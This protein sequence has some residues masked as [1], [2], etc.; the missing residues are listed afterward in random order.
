[1]GSSCS[2]VTRSPSIA[3]NSICVRCVAVD[4][5]WITLSTSGA[6]FALLQPFSGPMRSRSPESRSTTSRPLS[7]GR[8]RAVST[9][10]RSVSAPWIDRTSK[11]PSVTCSIAPPSRSPR[12]T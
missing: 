12:Q 11:S 3:S 5:E 9:T 2:I 8:L 6:T 10:A 4:Q 7:T 1:M